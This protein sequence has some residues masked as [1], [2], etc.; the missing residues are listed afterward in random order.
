[1]KQVYIFVF[2]SYSYDFIFF[3]DDFTTELLSTSVFFNAT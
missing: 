3:V 1:M 2:F